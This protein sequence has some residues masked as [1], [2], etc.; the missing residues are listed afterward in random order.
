MSKSI[1]VDTTRCI[2][3]GACATGCK[4]VNNLPLDDPSAAKELPAKALNDDDLVAFAQ[5]HGQVDGKL[6]ATTLN[7]V[8]THGSVFVR[9]FCMHCQEPTCAS[10]C[11]VGA[12]HKTAAGPVVYD[13]DKCMGCRYCMMACPFSIPRYEWKAVLPKVKKCTMCAPRQAKGQQP[14]CTL[15]CPVQ[16]GIFGERDDLLSQAEKRI[17][18]EPKKYFPHVYGKEEAGGTSVLYLS[19]VPFEQLGLPANLP[20]DP[21]PLLTFRV[22]SKLPYVVSLGGMLLA[23]IW[24]ITD[25]REEV[26]KAEKN[27]K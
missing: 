8:Q 11:P 6:S 14:A 17:R 1:L 12:L 23:G 9:R 7:V 24:W 21:L 2:G 19:A 18:D 22:L 4:I 25:R 15:V 20:T 3:C 27:A 16:A 26:A 5:S 10:V 13:A